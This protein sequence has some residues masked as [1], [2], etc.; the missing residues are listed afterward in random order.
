MF[1]FQQ[2]VATLSLITPTL[3]P[4]SLTQSVLP[5]SF[6]E[7]SCRFLNPRQRCLVPASRNQA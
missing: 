2:N 5:L 3:F 6:V 1:V 7:V 4:V